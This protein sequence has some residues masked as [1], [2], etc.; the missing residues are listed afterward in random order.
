MKMTTPEG[1]VIFLEPLGNLKCLGEMN[2]PCA[3]VLPAAKRLY[4][5][6]AP[7]H[8]VGFRVWRASIVYGQDRKKDTLKSVSFFLVP[9]G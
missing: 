2:S 3:R 6:K 1:V 7:P 4:G 8:R 5:V 9:G